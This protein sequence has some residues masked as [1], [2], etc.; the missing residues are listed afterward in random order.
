MLYFIIL[1]TIILLMLVVSLVCFLM[2]FYSPDRKPLRAD[3]YPIPDGDIY[4]PHREQM[5]KWMKEI[6]AMDRKNVSVISFDGL[7]LRGKYYD[8]KKGAPIEILFHGYKGSAERDMC[9]A[10]YRCFE[11]K[12]NALIVDQRAHGESEGHVITFGVK[13]SRDCLTW[14]DYAINNIDKHAKI[15]ITGIS[16]GAAT[17]MTAAGY[18]LPDNVV[19]VLSDCG[20]TSAEEIIKKVMKDMRLPPSFMYPF[21]RLG[22]I[23]FGRFDP[24]SR[25]PIKSMKNCRLPIIFLHGDADDFVPCYMSEKNYETCASEYK[26]LVITPGAG[27][28]LCFPLDMDA[29]FRE[30]RAFFDPILEEKNP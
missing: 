21:V 30:V 19:G 27:H 14:I 13:E 7:T 18:D 2:V 25:S 26:K 10:V 24:N 16:M 12:R 15:I 20:Y 1:V 3:E 29:Y 5:V 17:V 22:A 28:G 23:L 4:L 11:L 8:H 6:R 9:G